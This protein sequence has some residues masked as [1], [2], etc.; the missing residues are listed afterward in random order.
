MDVRNFRKGLKIYLNYEL[1]IIEELINYNSDINQ[2]YKDD[3]ESASTDSIIY[4]VG[5]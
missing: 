2:C 1:K 5:S 4:H 3:V